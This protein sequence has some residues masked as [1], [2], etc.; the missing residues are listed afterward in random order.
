MAKKFKCFISAPA[1]TDTSLLRAVLQE[2][3]VETYD[4]YDFQPGEPL[5]DLLKKKIKESDFALIVVTEINAN[6]FYEM[7]ISEGL[8]KPLFIIVGKDLKGPYFVDKYV[9]LKTDL[10]NVD[11]L[12]ISLSKFLESLRSGKS[13][14]RRTKSGATNRT[15]NNVGDYLAVVRSMR[16]E[17]S[18]HEVE[19]LA[20]EIFKK[21]NFQFEPNQFS[22]SQD[23]GVDYAIWN[24]NLA[25]A[26]GNP[27]LVE[28]KAGSLTPDVIHTTENRL[29][30]YLAQTTAKAGI[31]L[32]LDRKG[33]RFREDYSLDPLIL[34]YD[35][36]DFIEALSKSTFEDLV[37]ST[38]NRMIHGVSE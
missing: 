11:L 16:K 12:K 36:E 34:R 27:L 35:L 30:H 23:S 5:H 29:K 31:L 17:G 37:L 15:P 38:R 6:V 22:S 24:D 14:P 18:A 13:K 8:G 2:L 1:H 4:T 28:V 7:G 9:H 33:T 21:L 32:Y 20:D 25:F 19:K 26:V 3:D 10:R